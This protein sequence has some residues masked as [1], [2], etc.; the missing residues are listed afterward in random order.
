MPVDPP[1]VSYAVA[2]FQHGAGSGVCGRVEG[3]AVRIVVGLRGMA[4][5]TV[6][7]AFRHA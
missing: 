1:S 4:Q 3:V 6:R 2:T 7:K 5:E